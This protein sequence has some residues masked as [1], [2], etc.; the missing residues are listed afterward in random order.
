M[1]PNQHYM[2]HCLKH[3][4]KTTGINPY[5]EARELKFK[6]LVNDKYELSDTA[7]E[8]LEEIEEFFSIQKE[9]VLI[10]VAG[11]DFKENI[12]K[13]LELFPKRKLPSGKLARSDKK[14][15]E[16]NF[17]WFFKTFEYTWETVLTATAHYVDEYEKKNYLYMQTSQY[18]I[19][20]TQPDKSKMSELANYCSMI[21]EGTDMNDDNHFKERVV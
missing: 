17:K 4:V 11:N 1:T 10:T 6:G 18:F 21:I 9:K 7:N 15:I 16:S 13:Y 2:L 14:N 5:A 12:V 20:K 19:S 3:S 8:I